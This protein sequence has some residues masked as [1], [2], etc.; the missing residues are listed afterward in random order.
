MAKIDIQ[1]LNNSNNGTIGPV[2]SELSTIESQKSSY[3][4]EK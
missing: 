1:S 3:L 2:T 4:M